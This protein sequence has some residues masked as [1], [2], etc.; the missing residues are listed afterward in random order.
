MKVLCA[1]EPF[2]SDRAGFVGER[3][4]LRHKPLADLGVELSQRAIGGGSKLDS[5]PGHGLEP[6][7]SL[8]VAPSHAVFAGLEEREACVGDVGVI[9]VALKKRVEQTKVVH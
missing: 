9:L 3:C 1:R 8:D 7:L 5:V 6:E 4:D 2:R